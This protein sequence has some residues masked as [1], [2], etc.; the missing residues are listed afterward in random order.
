MN[1]LKFKTTIKC[2]GCVSKVTPHLDSVKEV[3][4]KW[5]VDI[6][7]PNK[8]LTVESENV[9]ADKIKEVVKNAGFQIEQI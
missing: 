1:T 2:D 9:S 5:T 7:N 6:L 3:A 8:V 4:G